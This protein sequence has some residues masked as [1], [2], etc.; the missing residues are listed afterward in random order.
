M[1]SPVF[2]NYV[3]DSFHFSS[4]LTEISN[5]KQFSKISSPL[6]FDKF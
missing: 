2:R 4:L 6:K 5:I 3:L 1:R